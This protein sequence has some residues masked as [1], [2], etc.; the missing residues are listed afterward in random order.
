MFDQTEVRNDANGRSVEFRFRVAGGGQP[1]IKE[2][3]ET[4]QKAEAWN[5]DSVSLAAG[6]RR[7]TKKVGTEQTAEAWNPDFV[8]LAAAMRPFWAAERNPDA[9]K[10]AARNRRSMEKGVETSVSLAA[11]NR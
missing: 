11:A 4:E 9:V 5:A 2:N 10:L 3:V 6:D 8:T 1:L 7:S